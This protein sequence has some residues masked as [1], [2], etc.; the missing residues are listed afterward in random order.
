M[1]QP[2]DLHPLIGSLRPPAGHRLDLAVGTTFS[3]KLDALLLPPAA[4]ALFEARLESDDGGMERTPVG[5]LESVRRHADRIIMFCQ[6]GQIAVPERRRLIP[7]LE[8]C[9]V[10][11]SVP[12]GGLFHPKVWVLRFRETST[13]KL[14][15]RLLNMSRNLT[16]DRSWDT[17][18]RLDST[19]GEDGAALGPGLAEFMRSL[20]EFATAVDQRRTELVEG[21][22]EELREVRFA[23]PE[24]ITAAEFLPIG[25]GDPNIE[26]PPECDQL[27]VMSPY[28]GARLLDSLPRA[29]GKSVLVSRAKAMDPVAD[30]TTRFD[31]R[32]VLSPD[33]VVR[34]T[35]DEQRPIGDPALPES[36]LHAKTYHF[37]V[38]TTAHLYTGSANATW[39]GFHHNVEVLLHLRG[40]TNSVG[41]SRLLAPSADKNPA[42]VDLLEEYR[43]SPAPK[44]SPDPLDALRRSVAQLHFIAEIT[45]DG[46][47]YVMSCRTEQPAPHIPEDVEMKI[48]PLTAEAAGG[49]PSRTSG[50]L[51]IR[52]VFDKVTDITSFLVIDFKSGDERTQTVVNAE[53]IGDPPDRAGKLILDLLNDPDRF[54]K[55]LLL[56]LAAEDADPFDLTEVN[57]GGAGS[58]NFQWGGT[59]GDIPLLETMLKA[60]SDDPARLDHVQRLLDDVAAV[61]GA[62]GLLPNGFAAV[63]EPIYTVSKERQA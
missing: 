42:F 16:F 53:L 36:G 23:L 4:F 35:E 27:L 24:G 62:E 47:L 29:R 31:S 20:A 22:S 50:H 51:D 41:I 9:V 19:E 39:A 48:W 57:E 61:E 60:L 38:G 15:Y 10:E 46:G 1:L 14:R 59:H 21:L 63:W 17:V 26:F 5:L 45:K 33:L 56:M 55:Y 52:F 54:L 8:R 3:L 11:V 6:A 58:G 18:V 7:F 40:P 32:Y 28:L 44:G 43:P 30:A 12:G 37:D 34:T 49:R 13:G 2:E 25:P